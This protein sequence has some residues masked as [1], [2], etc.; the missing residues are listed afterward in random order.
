MLTPPEEAL[1][2]QF[3]GHPS[4]V[5]ALA[6]PDQNVRLA[7]LRGEYLFVGPGIE[8]L[9]G[10]TPEKFLHVDT[11]SIVRADEKEILQEMVGALAEG[12]AVEVIAHAQHRDGSYIWVRNLIQ[13]FG[14]MLA[15]IASRTQ[16]PAG[17]RAQWRVIEPFMPDAP[18]RSN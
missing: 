12:N 10:F 9:L 8:K 3:C 2:E 6:H 15:A 7:S 5:E 1:V 18:A 17:G 16:S 13:P 14:N 4:I 11:W